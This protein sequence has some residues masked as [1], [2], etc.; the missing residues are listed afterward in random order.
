MRP[1]L[2]AVA[3]ARPRMA[4]MALGRRSFASQSILEM[5][6]DLEKARTDKKSSAPEFDWCARA[7]S[8][9]RHADRLRLAC[10]R[11]CRDAVAVTLCVLRAAC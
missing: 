10:V 1:A 2:R 8:R 11:H 6:L 7:T 4:T 3:V 5:Y 9:G